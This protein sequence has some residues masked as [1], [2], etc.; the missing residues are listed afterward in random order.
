MWYGFQVARMLWLLNRNM[1]ELAIE[2]RGVKMGAG[3]KAIY[4]VIWGGT[5][6]AV[7][8][9]AVYDRVANNSFIGYGRN[10]FC[11]ISG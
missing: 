4:G 2:H 3:E 6:L 11:L 9:L 7:A 8:A 5:L 10:E 1:A